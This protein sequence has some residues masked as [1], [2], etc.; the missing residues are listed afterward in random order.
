MHDIKI[1]ISLSLNK[2]SKVIGKV[3]NFQTNKLELEL[4]DGKFVEINGDELKQPEIELDK[5]I[6]PNCWLYATGDIATMR[7]NKINRILDEDNCR[8]V[9]T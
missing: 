9:K 8:F 7:Q 6:F 5:T 3:Y 1:K 2:R 4:E